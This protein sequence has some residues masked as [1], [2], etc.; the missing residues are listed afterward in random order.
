MA[1]CEQ[2]SGESAENL[3][4]QPVPYLSVASVSVLGPAQD[5]RKTTLWWIG[6]CGASLLNVGLW[7]VAT[8]VEMPDTTYRSWQLVLSGVYVAVCAFRSIFPRVDL[9]RLCLWDT[10][11]SAIFTGRSVATLAEM[12]FA[13]Q[14]TL[15]LSKLSEITRVASLDTLALWI[16]PVIVIAQLSCWYAVITL[17]HLGHVVEE[18]LW[19]FIVALLAVGFANAWLHTHGVLRI[20][21]SMGIVCGGAAVLLMGLIDVPMYIARWRHHRRVATPYL[22]LWEG[23]QD[24]LARRHLTRSWIV[25]RREVPWM[26]LYFSVG[27]WL[28]I[29]MA[30]VESLTP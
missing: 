3:V 11:L 4:E 17:N 2:S 12:C 26:T 27:V 22:P 25:W 8:R 30:L 10:P 14:C 23:L 21:L 19:T 1:L 29:G 28:S 15:F 13:V 6:L 18:L 9:E 5:E 20:V 24:T 16:V 7:L